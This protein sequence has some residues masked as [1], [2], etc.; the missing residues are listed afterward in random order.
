MSVY[1]GYDTAYA[2]GYL[3]RQAHAISANK[4]V[5]LGPL[6][7][8][9]PNP[10]NVGHKS[11]VSGFLGKQ[12]ARL[13]ARLGAEV[14]LDPVVTR[15]LRWEF[16]ASDLVYTMFLWNAVA[17]LPLHREARSTAVHI[18]G[19]DATTLASVP[20]AVARRRVRAAER[21]DLL[22]CGSQFLAEV[23]QRYAPRLEPVVHYIGVDVPDIDCRPRGSD[24][25]E[26]VTVSRLARVKGV[27]RTIRAFALAFS[28]TPDAYLT[29][30]GDGSQRKSLESLAE[31]LPVHERIQFL[32][33]LDGKAVQQ[34]L[35]RSHVFAQH[36][37]LVESGSEEA[38][39]GSLLE[40]SA[41]CL[42][43]V[44]TRSGGVSEAVIDGETGLLSEPDDIPT[45]AEHFRALYASPSLRQRLGKG[46]RRH[47]RQ[48]H[49]SLLQDARLNQLLE[50]VVAAK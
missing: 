50:S 34:V 45:M 33:R 29:I 22:L 6:P 35:L 40:A 31:S 7:A 49:N 23:M 27:D 2:G 15:R 21:S 47:V 20:S 30:V 41:V 42:P 13:M 9:L 11:A 5:A 18:G 37:V 24:C 26:V 1:F 8:S 36:N 43:V 46:G 17:L 16:A 19:S 32:G 48:S 3:A 38:L 28:D 4:C 14:G 44:G 12:S 10:I 25:F 39:G